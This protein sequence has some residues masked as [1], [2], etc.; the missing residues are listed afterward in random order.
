VDNEIVG[1]IQKFPYPIQKLLIKEAGAVMNRIENGKCAPGLTSLDCDCLFMNK[2]L[3]PCKHIFHEHMYGST[4]LL[5]DDVWRT[6]Q[7]MFEESGFEIYERR[8]QITIL[9]SRTEEQRRT[10]S[11]RLTVNEL[12]ERVRDM[13]WRVEESGSAEQVDS[14]IENLERSLNPILREESEQ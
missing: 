3:L 8:E 2:Y 13:Y 4:K 9:V 6:F 5:T 1:E 10:D 11:R 14:F 7:N 12:M